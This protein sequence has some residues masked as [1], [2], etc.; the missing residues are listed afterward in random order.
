M[1]FL[2]FTVLALIGLTTPC[3]VGVPHESSTLNVPRLASSTGTQVYLGLE[4]PASCGGYL[5]NYTICYYN[6]NAGVSVYPGEL[7]I[8]EVG[9]GLSNG[10]RVYDKIIESVLNLPLTINNT[11]GIDPVVTP[12][13]DAPDPDPAVEIVC[14]Y[15][16]LPETSTVLV[17]PGSVVGILYPEGVGYG[18]G[19]ILTRHTL[20]TVGTCVGID[21]RF[22]LGDLVR[23]SCRLVPAN[24]TT[25]L[26]AGA[27][28]E[29]IYCPELSLQYG[30]INISGPYSYGTGI[31]YTCQTGFQ[32]VGVSS[33]ICLSSGNWS[34]ELPYC[35]VLNCTDPGVPSNGNH[36]LRSFTNGSSG[37]FYCDNGFTLSGNRLITCYRGIWNAP[38]P[39]C[40]PLVPTTSVPNSKIGLIAGLAVSTILVFII[41][42]ILVIVIVI[43]RNKIKK[44]KKQNC[45][46]DM[47]ETN[48]SPAY[49]L[50]NNDDDDDDDMQY[51]QTYDREMRT[52]A[53][54]LSLDENYARIED[55]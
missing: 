26:L 7:S 3:N 23:V 47:I 2:T 4:N 44:I 54:I 39:D 45:D 43:F 15:Y 10:F 13:S 22:S 27:G 8:W 19:Q 49:N 52:Y 55:Y 24:T 25:A 1:I 5:Q 14:M 31:E 50:L 32:L 35:N 41:T 33:Q 21:F 18:R 38:V 17:K 36:D 28:I 46:V 20:Q 12:I 16:C 51:N 48:E 42:M 9:P 6:R 53:T 29:P 40:V 30:S 34:D 37:V 11:C